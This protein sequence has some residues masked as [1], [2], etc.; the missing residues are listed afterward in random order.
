VFDVL[1]RLGREL[2]LRVRVLGALESLPQKTECVLG[3][4]HVAGGLLCDSARPPHARGRLS[5]FRVAED[6]RGVSLGGRH[7]SQL[8]LLL[9]R[10]H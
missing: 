8:T 7:R 3:L 1:E 6:E 9:T 10:L 4:A 2:S 5:D